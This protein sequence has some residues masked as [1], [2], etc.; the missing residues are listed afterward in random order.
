[1][2]HTSYKRR[3]YKVTMDIIQYTVFNY[4]SIGRICEHIDHRCSYSVVVQDQVALMDVSQLAVTHNMLQNLSNRFRNTSI[5][6][7]RDDTGIPSRGQTKWRAVLRLTTTTT[8][9]LRLM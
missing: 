2:K 4:H 9:D 3:T 6:Y 8:G 1:M 7:L 5:R